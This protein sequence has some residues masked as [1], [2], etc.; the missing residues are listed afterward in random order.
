[1]Y[2]V[3]DKTSAIKEVQ[4]FLHIIS[5]KVN[6]EIPRI[7]VDGVYGDETFG[8]VKIFQELYGLEKSGLVDRETFDMLFLLYSNAADDFNRSGYLLTEAG[9]PLKLGDNSNDVLALHLIMNE[10]SCAYT[11]ICETLRGTYYSLST[12]NAVKN[13]QKIFLHEITGEVDALLYE[14][15][16]TELAAIR[17]RDKKYI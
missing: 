9:F 5:D 1:M 2:E 4:K 16:Q 3:N 17:K 8:A 15:M 6:L 13:L 14:R 7:A 12:E 10:I 11:D